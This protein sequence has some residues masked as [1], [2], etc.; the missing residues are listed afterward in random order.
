VTTRQPMLH[1]ENADV[2]VD[3][4]APET[5]V[6]VVIREA[7]RRQRRRWFV[8]GLGLMVVVFAVAVLL[9]TAARPGSIVP[10][11]HHPPSLL[12][13]R[14]P[15]DLP[16]GALARLQSAGPLAVASD[17]TVYVADRSRHQILVRL[18]NGGFRVIAG[19][20][21]SGYAGDGG[22]A[23]KAELSVVSAM[24]VAPNGD[25]TVADGTR[26]RVIDRDGTIRTVV[27][28]GRT[29][30]SVSNGTPA[31]EASLGA[32]SSVA[33]SPSGQLYLATQN[34]L[35]RV[36]ASGLLQT[37]PAT[38][39]AP[40][41]PQGP[42]TG[43]GTIA[44]DA[45]GN[46][47]VSTTTG[48]WSVWEVSPQGDA[49]ELGYARRSGGNT[50]QVERGANDQI[51]A[52]DGSNVVQVTPAGLSPVLSV[53]TLPGIRDF[54]FLSYFAIAPDGTIVADNLGP[55]A[56]EPY[57]QI[58]SIADGRGSSLWHGPTRR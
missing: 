35:F 21:T 28:D 6:E 45:Q 53:D 31:L 3:T 20:G 15:Q 44:V 8:A 16:A 38:V 54:I 12:E 42:L 57:G 22:P 30:G 27:G 46:I 17:G 7:R 5:A 2:P 9:V 29:G 41:V 26:V 33:F 4:A 14:S 55:P 51:Y 23:L 1:R 40:G 50:A 19:D 56:F 32:V 13:P 39:P 11:R 25:L 37:A 58:V 47:T 24:T 18:P 48:G 43:L 10:H 49:V 36:T 34:Q 52:D